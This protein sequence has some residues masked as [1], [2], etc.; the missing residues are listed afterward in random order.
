MFNVLTKIIH[1]INNQKKKQ[2][3]ISFQRFPTVVIFAHCVCQ[4][5]H[6]FIFRHVGLLSYEFSLSSRT[7]RSVVKDLESI[8]YV[9]L[10]YVLP[11]FFLPSVV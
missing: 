10:Y 8:H 5:A 7:E 9:F 11:R 3:N 1:F 6:P 4:N 2:E